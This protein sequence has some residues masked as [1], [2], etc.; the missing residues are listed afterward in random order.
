M[1]GS[2]LI[3]SKAGL[4]QTLETELA[5]YRYRVFVEELGWQLPG[6]DVA[7]GLERDQFDTESTVYV[8]RR[9]T[10]GAICGC[11]RLLSTDGP[12]LLKEVFPH[13]FSELDLPNSS[14]VWELSRLAATNFNNPDDSSDRGTVELLRAVISCA[15]DNGVSQIIGVTYVSLERRLRAMGLHVHRAGPPRLWEGALLVALYIEID[16]VTLAALDTFE[17]YGAAGAS[18]RRSRWA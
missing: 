14:D 1:E 9:D 17:R 2:I 12:Y 13:L 3:A 7:Q 11:A 4:Q 6:D 8:I 16:P 15:L 18:V 10:Q 5:Q